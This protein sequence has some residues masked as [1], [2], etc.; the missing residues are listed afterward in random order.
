LNIVSGRIS[1]LRMRRETS[2]RPSTPAKM[3]VLYMVLLASLCGFTQQSDRT[4][5]ASE[6]VCPYQPALEQVAE[7]WKKG[8][9]DG[10]AA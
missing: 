2:V 7:Q 6:R 5:K 3:A 8:Y 4:A 10:H 9:N 1:V